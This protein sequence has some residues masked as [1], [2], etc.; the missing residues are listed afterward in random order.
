MN[1]R[2]SASDT[3]LNAPVRQ[4]GEWQ[5]WLVDPTENQ[6][7]VYDDLEETSG[8]KALLPAALSPLGKRERRSLT[9]RRLKDMPA[10]L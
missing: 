7:T 10:T 5:D 3:S 8:C 4:E 1:R 9:E 2:L 6:E